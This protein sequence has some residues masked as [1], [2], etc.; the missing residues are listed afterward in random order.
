MNDFRK[1]IQMTKFVEEIDVVSVLWQHTDGAIGK[2]AHV[3]IQHMDGN[4]ITVRLQNGVH[5]SLCMENDGRITLMGWTDKSGSDCVFE[6][7]IVDADGRPVE[8][9]LEPT[10]G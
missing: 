10:A 6:F 3:H 9:P 4:M 1:V 7:A 8:K 2:A 5:F